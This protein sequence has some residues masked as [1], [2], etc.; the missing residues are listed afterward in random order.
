MK[1]MEA[2]GANGSEWKQMEVNGSKWKQMEV[3]GS[4]WK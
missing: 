3:N 2:N 4:K 1:G